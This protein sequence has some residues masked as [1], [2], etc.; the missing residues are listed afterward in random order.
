MTTT[1]VADGTKIKTL[2]DFWRIIGVAVNGQGG[3]FGRDADAFADCVSGGFGTP[4]DD[5][6]TV[7]RQD[8]E[9]SCTHLGHAETA[10]QLKIRLS[11]CH[12]ESRPSVSADLAAARE[13]R[14]PTVC[15]W[16]LEISE[17]RAPGTLRL[18]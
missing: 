12:P 6:R 4:D 11:R 16:L 18:R 8:H 17:D 5:D 15:D 7:V 14:G 10:R 9:T 2:E 13:G 3:C 1:S